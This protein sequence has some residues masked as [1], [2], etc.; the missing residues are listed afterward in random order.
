MAHFKADLMDNCGVKEDEIWFSDSIERYT[1]AYL[2]NRVSL[3]FLPLHAHHP[4]LTNPFM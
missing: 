1:C 4:D 3:H 2:R